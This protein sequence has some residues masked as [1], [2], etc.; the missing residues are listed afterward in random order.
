MSS[1][2]ASA[3]GN[4]LLFEDIIEF[5]YQRV[6]GLK[7]VKYKDWIENP[8]QYGK[9][10]IIRRY[11]YQSDWS[12]TSKYTELVVISDKY[13]IPE[14]RIECKFQYYP[15]TVDEKLLFTYVEMCDVPENNIIIMIQGNGPRK[16]IINKLKKW[17]DNKVLNTKNKNIR[18]I[19]F[20]DHINEITKIAK[21]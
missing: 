21:K 10:L 19:D 3:V 8:S 15:G 9:E 2:G 7:T 18:I 6:L 11:P 1:Q 13:N 4:G 16:T 5:T 14:T 20:N 17:C 12:S